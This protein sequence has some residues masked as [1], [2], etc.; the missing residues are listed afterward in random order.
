MLL[1]WKIR[2]GHCYHHI[3]QNAQEAELCAQSLGALDS[4]RYYKLCEKNWP[5]RPGTSLTL[6]MGPWTSSILVAL[7]PFLQSSAWHGRCLIGAP[8]SVTSHHLG[9]WLW[10]RWT[11]DIEQVLEAMRCLCGQWQRFFC[12]KSVAE[13]ECKGR[14]NNIS[15]NTNTLAQSQ[16]DA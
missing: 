7:W 12:V 14:Q 9:V 15:R 13:G 5:G 10:F 6:R 4:V 8:V 3:S 16:Q 1:I 11:P 2:Q